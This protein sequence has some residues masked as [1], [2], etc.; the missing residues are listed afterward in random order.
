MCGR[1]SLSHQI[2][3]VLQSFELDVDAG[4]DVKPSYNIAPTQQIVTVWQEEG[5]AKAGTMRWGLIPF[6]MKSFPKSAP[7]IN[8]RA[9]TVKEKP[10]FRAAYKKRR[11]LIPA[12]G[13]YEWKKLD[14]GK[15]PYFIHGPGNEIFAFAGLWE[16]WQN[17]SESIMSCTIITIEANKEMSSVHH[18]QPV[19]IPPE[20]YNNWLNSQD[21]SEL[22]V[23]MDGYFQ[24]YPVGRYVNSPANNSEKCIEA[25]G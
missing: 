15:Q 2:Q 20:H 13:F 9:E 19:I 5:T 12:D 17:D 23:P 6:W 16:H 4:L 8:A 3:E 7:M 10:A 14:Q 18:R 22:L 25:L 24:M 1:F 21:P 11:C